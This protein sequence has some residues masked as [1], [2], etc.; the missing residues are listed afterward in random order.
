MKLSDYY[1]SC[2]SSTD[3]P[4]LVEKHPKIKYAISNGNWN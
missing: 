4:S 1:F 2:P 3:V